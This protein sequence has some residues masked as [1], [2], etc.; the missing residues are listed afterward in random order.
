MRTRDCM[1][2]LFSVLSLQAQEVCARPPIG[3]AVENPPSLS[4]SKGTLQLD[5]FFRTFVDRYRQTRFCYVTED[6]L[7][8]P[9]L[10]VKPGDEVVLR[11]A[12]QIPPAPDSE[13]HHAAGC[14]TGAMTAS[15]TN[16]HFH[17]LDLP[18]TCHQDETLGTRVQPDDPA[19][20]YRFK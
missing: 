13:H 1:A 19:F 15:S 20:E 9:T 17:G 6:R 11:L 4:S 16:L 12:N 2:V 7:Q 5:L 18:P 3:S 10:R 14:T 8:A